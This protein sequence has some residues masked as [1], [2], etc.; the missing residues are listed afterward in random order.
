MGLQSGHEQLIRKIKRQR[1]RNNG[2]TYHILREAVEES[3]LNQ[4]INRLIGNIQKLDAEASQFKSDVSDVQDGNLSVNQVKRE[5]EQIAQ[6]IKNAADSLIGIYN[7]TDNLEGEIKKT[8]EVILVELCYCFWKGLKFVEHAVTIL[9][10]SS[11]NKAYKKKYNEIKSEE[12][13]K[14]AIKMSGS[15]GVKSDYESS[16]LNRFEQN[17]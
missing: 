7:E 13:V 3:S 6:D 15:Y 10:L 1:N 14:I 12:A 16:Q 5:E 2:E 11:D 4:D 8:L 17:F 9:T